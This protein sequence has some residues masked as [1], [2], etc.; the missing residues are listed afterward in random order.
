MKLITTGPPK[1]GTTA[2]KNLIK[3]H[4]FEM[5]P[6]AV[7]YDIWKRHTPWVENQKGLDK[8]IVK[9]NI[10][11]MPPEAAY[12][13]LTDGL[14]LHGHIPPP[15]PLDIPTIVILREPRAAMVSWFRAKM[16]S[17]R[18]LDVRTPNPV[19][20]GMF[21]KWMKKSAQ[22]A[23][24]Y[25]RPIYD[26]WQAEEA[27][28]TLLIIWYEDLFTDEA[29]QSI[30]DFIGRDPIDWRDLYGRGSKFSGQPTVLDGW[31]DDISEARFQTCWENSDVQSLGVQSRRAR[32]GDHARG[33]GPSNSSGIREPE[34]GQEP[35]EDRDR[36]DEGLL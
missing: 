15:T 26:G 6:G 33:V 21:R 4:G 27:R 7:I 12:K 13:A 5:L 28:D 30:A 10:R 8:E 34:V 17:K 1:C 9:Q 3:L 31:Y 35:D 29:M 25:I 14:T 36:D 22:R 2:L 24:D 11:N 18:D 23:T 20:L 19:V 16:S 32:V